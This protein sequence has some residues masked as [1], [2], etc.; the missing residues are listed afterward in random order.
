MLHE[1][2]FAETKA[3]PG[4]GAGQNDLESPPGSSQEEEGLLA[5][6]KV[7]D[8]WKV[9]TLFTLFS[10][11]REPNQAFVHRL[12]IIKLLGLGLNKLPSHYHV[13]PTH[14]PADKGA[15]QSPGAVAI[16]QFTANH[17]SF[18]PGSL[19]AVVVYQ[20]HHEVIRYQSL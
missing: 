13:P 5:V 18:G 1:E 16:S 3:G 7:V 12:R 19:H 11:F 4:A 9:C 20:H 2:H 14:V 10:G 17:F 15:P 8:W 6:L